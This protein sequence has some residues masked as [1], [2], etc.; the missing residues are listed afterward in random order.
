VLLANMLVATFL[1]MWI[2]NVAAPVLC[3]SLVL[4]VLR[5]M[6]PPNHPFAKSLVLGIALASNVSGSLGGSWGPLAH[7]AGCRTAYGPAFSPACIPPAHV[8]VCL[9]KQ[10]LGGGRQQACLAIQQLHCTAPRCASG[11]ASRGGPVRLHPRQSARGRGIGQGL[12]LHPRARAD[13]GS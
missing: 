13:K 8:L 12:L 7:G 9:L 3:Y 4:P 11:G 10:R 6:S 5:T 2:S 1:S